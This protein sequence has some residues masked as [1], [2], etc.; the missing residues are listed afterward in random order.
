MKRR[1]RLLRVAKWGGMV[2]CLIPASGYLAH[3]FVL[4]W[5]DQTRCHCISIQSGYLKFSWTDPAEITWGGQLGWFVQKGHTVWNRRYTWWPP[6]SRSVSVPPK[7]VNVR[8]WFLCLL[9]AVPTC[10]LW[11][12]DR[13]RHDSPGHCPCGYNLRG[14]VSGTCPECGKARQPG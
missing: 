2:V 9:L 8:L 3:G 7:W 11:R 13:R 5:L 12:L 10:W 6:V 4:G 14:N 1:S